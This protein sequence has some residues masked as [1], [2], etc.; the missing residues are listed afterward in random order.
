[1]RSR[2]SRSR[3]G[4]TVADRRDRPATTRATIR[5]T[6]SQPIRNSPA[7]AVFA[8]CCASQAATSS[9]SR[10][11]R[12]PGRAHPTASNCAPQSGQHTLRSSHSITQR[13]EPRSRWRHRLCRRSW[14]CTPRPVCP[15]REQTSRWRPRRTVTI[16]PSP[17]KLTAMTAAPRRRSSLLNAVVTRTSSSSQAA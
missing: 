13:V 11:E 12:E 8:I 10:V 9:K 14:W 2:R 1:M 4:L 3:P 5:P 16:T 17:L 15:Q 6:E 7:I